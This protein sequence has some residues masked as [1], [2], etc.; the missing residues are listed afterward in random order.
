MQDREFR[1][2]EIAYL[3]WEAEGRPIGQAE[4]HW[5]MA[6]SA[7]EQEEAERTQRKIVEGEPPGDAP[8]DDAAEFHDFKSASNADRHAA[9]NRS[10]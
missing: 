2:M 6:K 8:A 4:R 5:R 7:L 3:I 9:P 10:D 1:L